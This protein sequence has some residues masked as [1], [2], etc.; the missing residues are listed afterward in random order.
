MTNFILVFAGALLLNAA[1]TFRSSDQWKRWF[2]KAQIQRDEAS[3]SP[4]S[5]KE[6]RN[7]IV[8]YM[9][10]YLLATMSDWLQGPYVYALYHAYGYTQHDIAILF[11]AGF[12]SSAVFGS[13][14]GSMADRCGRRMFVV[15]YAIIYAVSCLTKRTCHH[16]IPLQ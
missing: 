3:Q 10:V 9:V 4:E 8:R 15:A 14:I 13:F 1:L 5:K 12:G 7:L 11:I 6:W 2:D 16:E